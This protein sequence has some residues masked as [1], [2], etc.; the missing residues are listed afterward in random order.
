MRRYL[1][2]LIVFP[3]APVASVVAQPHQDS[4]STPHHHAIKFSP[5][6][7]INFYPTVQVA[8]EY[9][10]KTEWTVQI[11]A[12]VVVRDYNYGVSQAYRD[13]RG[14]KV[15]AEARYYYEQ[16]YSKRKSYYVAL[17][18]YYNAVNFDRSLT[19]TECFDLECTQLYNRT[20]NYVVNYREPGFSFKIGAVKYISHSFF[21]DFN[22]GLTMRFINYKKPDIIGG[23]QDN[24]INGFR[25]DFLD[26]PNEKSRI[27]YLPALGFRVGYKI[28]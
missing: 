21:F 22:T 6:H 23:F 16:I 26:V 28:K 18:V 13:K 15:K 14:V 25:D 4:V 20:Y 27:G 12:G 19:Q 8:Y 7:L 10:I 17:E 24:G 5:F 2:W 11:D 1:H 9:A 3:I